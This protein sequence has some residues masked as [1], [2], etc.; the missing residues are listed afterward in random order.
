MWHLAPRALVS[1]G[2]GSEA[3]GFRASKSP[4]SELRTAVSCC[5]VFCSTHNLLPTCGLTCFR[6]G[7]L[8]VCLW[9]DMTDQNNTGRRVGRGER[10]VRPGSSGDELRRH[11]RGGQGRPQDPPV[12]AERDAGVRRHSVSGCR[13][14]GQG[15][16][17]CWGLLQDSGQT[18]TEAR[19]W[20][21]PQSRR[22]LPP[23]FANVAWS[24]FICCHQCFADQ[25][26]LW[27]CS[28]S[29]AAI[30]ADVLRI[31]GTI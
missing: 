1:T 5:V 22:I 31:V 19:I 24:C 14:L 28:R 7:R 12:Q 10:V 21:C 18:E 6:L 29:R 4:F 30:S 27:V 9:D 2:T 3:T 13:Q 11:R 16:R 23:Q 20:R 26:R 8:M 17:D 15:D 25:L